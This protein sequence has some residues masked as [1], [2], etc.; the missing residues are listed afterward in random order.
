MLYKKTGSPVFLPF[1]PII[2]VVLYRNLARNLVKIPLHLFLPTRNMTV[3]RNYT[4]ISVMNEI[5]RVCSGNI[6]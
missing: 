5:V 6:L 2:N 1:M 3:V 4:N